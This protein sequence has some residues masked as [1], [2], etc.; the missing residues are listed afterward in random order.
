M[1]FDKVDK[2]INAAIENKINIHNGIEIIKKD[3]EFLR[4]PSFSINQYDFHLQ[5]G[6]EQ[7]EEQFTK[8]LEK[9][10]PPKD[11]IAFNFG[12]YQ[13]DFNFHLYITG[14]RQWDEDDE[15]W[16]SDNDY[17]PEESFSKNNLYKKLYQYWRFNNDL[18]LFLTIVSTVMLVNTYIDKY[19]DKFRDRTV[20]A[21]GFDDGDLYTFH[22]KG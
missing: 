7:F 15:G 2:L 8:I 3:I 11:I 10:L 6:Y 17:F 4:R 5:L 1:D 14:S 22:L 13:T 9:D 12:I 18:G 19:P 20:F 16:A 21:T